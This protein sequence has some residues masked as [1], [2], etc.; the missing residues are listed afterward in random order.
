MNCESVLP[1][2]D[3]LVFDL[4][5]DQTV[6]ELHEH[7]TQCP[8]CSQR[9]QKVRGDWQALDDWTLGPVVTPDA[10]LL[11]RRYQAAITADALRP[12]H[13]LSG[14]LHWE[15]V[16]ARVQNKRSVFCA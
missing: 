12:S 6:G 4:L 15:Q 13:S 10:D 14:L 5:D 2:L 1:L 8:V 7:L 3:A 11:I 16:L 9:L